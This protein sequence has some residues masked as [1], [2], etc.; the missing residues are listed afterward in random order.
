M[1]DLLLELFSEEIPARMQRKAAEDL[2]KLVT[3]ALVER[4]LVYEGAKAY[5]TPRRLALHVVGLPAKGLDTTEE[6]K[7]PRANAPAPALQGFFKS[8]GLS[9]Q[10]VAGL[11]LTAGH[12][13]PL[14]ERGLTLSVRG[15]G[16]QAILFAL[17]EKKGQACVDAL[18]QVMPDIVRK[19]PWPKSM[20]WGTASQSTSSLRWVRPLQSIACVLSSDTGEAEI[21]P[22]EVDGL[23]A[24]NITYGHRFMAPTHLTVKRFEDY[25]TSLEAAFVVLDADRRKSIIQTD[26]HTLAFAQG[27]EVVDDEG[28]REE[29][30][31]LVEWPCV[32]MGHFDEAF[33]SIPPEVIRATI[34]ANQK[35][36]VLRRYAPFSV[37]GHHKLANAFMLVSN[38]AASDEGKAIVQGNERVV[39]ARL[40]DAQF[41]WE[42][43]QKISLTT[44]AEKLKDIV[45]HEKLGTQH[46]R[47]ERLVTLARYIAPLVK[48]D[49]DKAALA[50]RLCK[51][52]LVTDMVGE[53]PELQGL[54]G[55][56]YAQIE[57]LDTSICTALED[58]YKPQGPSDRVPNDEV[59]I[60]LALADKL[61]VLVGFWLMNEKPTG[62]KDPY[63]LRRAA[64]GVI[65]IL[66]ENKITL[67][68]HSV[69]KVAASRY[70]QFSGLSDEQSDDLIQFFI[71]RLKVYLKDQGIK[72]DLIES[73]LTPSGTDSQKK[74]D[75]L[76]KVASRV[77][78]LRDFLSTEDGKNVLAGYRRA[79]NILKAEEKKDGVG[80]FEA[81]VDLTLIALLNLIEEK[82]LVVSINHARDEVAEALRQENDTEA[83]AAL[84]KLRAPVDAF[85]EH[86]TVNAENDAVRLNRL[87]LLAGL[88][89]V[90][91]QVCDFGKIVG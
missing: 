49:E 1:P 30:A 77:H 58:H 26:A 70:S 84:A 68:L 46:E 28:L 59:A 5:A 71:E 86:I 73:A 83:M 12:S 23:T 13:Y 53:F 80:A 79:A 17:I 31:G 42:N 63:A 39:R 61:D 85:F 81:P 16:E 20:R 66:I 37:D 44:R 82:T 69:L 11:N 62:S 8:I 60:A 55:R 56:Y 45:F 29:V 54:M 78:A 88:R 38:L 34:R 9:A 3:D 91:L 90:T 24:S 64:L 48:A 47:V 75:D 87:K 67:S 41:F 35:C 21:V 33:L 74:P 25:V 27:L 6:R 15:S 51:A 2:R 7:G 19:F 14:P 43:D 18:M 65:R 32:L 76:L 10:D 50:A 72:H 22:F 57:G 40:S 89:A 52:D 4:G 36:F